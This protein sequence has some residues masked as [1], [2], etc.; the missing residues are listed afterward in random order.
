MKRTE[1]VRAIGEIVPRLISRPWQQTPLPRA[2]I[3][4][5]PPGTSAW[6]GITGI[7]SRFWSNALPTASA[8]VQLD[9]WIVDAV[10][11]PIAYRWAL[12]GVAVTVGVTPGD[13]LAP[14]V[15]SQFRRLGDL[16]VGVYVV[17]SGVAHVYSPDYGL[18]LGTKP[19]GTVTIPERIGYHVA[20]IRSVLR[21][22]V[23]G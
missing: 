10:A 23:T 1:R 2:T 22:T 12:S 13:A 17:W 9:G 19:L 11:S 3:H 14:A 15:R 20:E 16:D 6:P 8:S 5:S 7:E 4:A 18:D 21:T